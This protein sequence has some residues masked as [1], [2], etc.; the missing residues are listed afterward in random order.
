MSFPDNCMRGIANDTYLIPDGLVAPHLFEFKDRDTRDDGW[1]E[2]SI[3]WQD[4]EAAIDFTLSQT[5]ETGE[6]QF[7][8]G[9]AMVPR[10]EIDRLNRRPAVIGLLSY[11]R[12]PLDDNPYHGSILVQASVPKPTRKMIAAGLALAVSRI[13]MQK[14]T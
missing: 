6:L 1:I 10:D 12:Q 7:R 2:Q 4:D 8:A 9:V 14:Q 11:E 5:K 3:N 13:V